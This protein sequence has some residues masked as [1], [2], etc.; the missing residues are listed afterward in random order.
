MRKHFWQGDAVNDEEFK[1]RLTNLNAHILKGHKV[2]FKIDEFFRACDRFSK[3]LVSDLLLRKSLTQV[4]VDSGESNAIDAEV[5]I[6]EIVSF[7]E[8]KALRS[9]L[10]AEFGNDNPFRSQKVSK[11]R[12]VFESWFPLG[13]LVQF[14]ASNAPSLAVLS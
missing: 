8:E 11:P 4:L 9:K 5:A 2:E 7:I 1:N 12:P 10:N 6:D 14:L 3:K 13:F